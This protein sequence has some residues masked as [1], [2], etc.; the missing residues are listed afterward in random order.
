MPEK[1]LV[2]GRGFLGEQ[3]VKEIANIQKIPIGTQFT[4]IE[5]NNELRV[6]VRDMDSIS[7]CVL[8]FKPD[9]IVNCAANVSLDFLENNEEFAFAVNAYG[10]KNVA[11]IAKREKIRLVHISTDGVFDGT[12]GMYQENDIPHPINVYGKSKLLG[13]QFV[14]DNCDDHVII[15][16]NFYGIDRHG[17]HLLNWIRSS[18][19]AKKQIIGFDDIIFTPLEISNLCEMIT[20]TASMSYKGILHLASNDAISKYDFA[21]AVADAFGLDKGLIKKGTSNDVELV[22]KRPK[23]TSLS[24]SRSRELLKTKIIPLNDSLKKL[25]S[26]E[27]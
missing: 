17:R 24:N 16:T 6:D 8:R 11:E 9:L 19:E 2:I 22:A 13:E 10:A 27:S 26:L 14:K 7:K 4:K 21:L 20:E 25:A 15:R 1:I 18:L 3:L 23:N 12:G 5:T